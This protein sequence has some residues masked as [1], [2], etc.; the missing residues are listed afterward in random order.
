MVQKITTHYDSPYIPPPAP[1][2]DVLSTALI[3]ETFRE[4]LLTDPER[5][6]DEGYLGEPFHLTLADRQRILAIQADSLEELAAQ[7]AQL[8]TESQ[9]TQVDLDIHLQANSPVPLYQQLYMHLQQSIEQG[10]LA[11][12]TQLPSERRLAAEYGVSRLTARRAFQ[13]LK[14]EGYVVAQQ[15]RGSFVM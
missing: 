15:G 6:L 10:T 11:I 5:A 8:Y 13:R 4:L 3:N 7:I 1:V 9:D 14:Q 2:T 12:G